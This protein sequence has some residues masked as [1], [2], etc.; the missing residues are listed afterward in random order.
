MVGIRGAQQV[1]GVAPGVVELQLLGVVVLVEL[2][3]VH[4]V[5]VGVA[6][7]VVRVGLD[8]RADD[9][10][11]AVQLLPPGEPGVAGRHAHTVSTDSVSSTA[12]A[13]MPM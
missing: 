8:R 3:E 11:L 9:A 13:T 2:L 4:L 6:L 1:R 7:G 10:A 12:I 5:A